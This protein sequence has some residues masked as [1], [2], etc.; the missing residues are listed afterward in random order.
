M[1]EKMKKWGRPLRFTAGGALVGLCYCHFVGCSSGA[2]PLTS[3]PV[4]TMAYMG[5]VG[6][7]LSGIWG[8]GGKDPCNMQ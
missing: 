1:K 7:L 4:S 5:V 3:N 8:K 2:C 6:L